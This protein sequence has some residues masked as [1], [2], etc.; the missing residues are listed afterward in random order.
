MD[1]LCNLTKKITSAD[2]T[3]FFKFTSVWKLSTDLEMEKQLKPT[4][5]RSYTHY[6]Q[7]LGQKMEILV[8]ENK[9]VRF[10]RFSQKMI[11]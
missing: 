8:I 1:E 10:V 11:F 5:A 4:Y 2:K 9:N 6:P 7:V 3:S